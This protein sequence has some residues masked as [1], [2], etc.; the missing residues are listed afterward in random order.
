MD[1]C[2]SQRGKPEVKDKGQN[3]NFYNEDFSKSDLRGFSQ[4]F[5]LSLH[6]YEEVWSWCYQANFDKAEAVASMKGRDCAF[7]LDSEPQIYQWTR[8]WCYQHFW[9]G[10]HRLAF[11]SPGA[12]T[13]RTSHRDRRKPNN[14]HGKT[15]AS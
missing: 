12:S 15:Q 14:V 9:S 13:L 4:P 2:I 7:S 1:S 8:E 11:S 10:F 3:D 5:S 6:P